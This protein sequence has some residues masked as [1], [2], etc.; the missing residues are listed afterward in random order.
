MWEE[1]G[2]FFVQLGVVG[3]LLRVFWVFR[4]LSICCIMNINIWKNRVYL[5][6]CKVQ[7]LFMRGY[8]FLIGTNKM[9]G[10]LKE[11]EKI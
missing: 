5:E 2:E 11:E 7:L 3:V 4:F 9:R 8:S 10:E 6:G 1:V